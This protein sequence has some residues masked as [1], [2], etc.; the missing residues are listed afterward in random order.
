[1]CNFVKL[2]LTITQLTLEHINFLQKKQY[3]FGN[4]FYYPTYVVG[5]INGILIVDTAAASQILSD[6]AAFYQDNKFVYIANREMSHDVDLTVYKLINP[7]KM[8]GIAIVAKS[9]TAKNQI[10]QEQKRY[11]G[12]FGYFKNMHSAISWAQLLMSQSV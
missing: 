7:K 4:V 11:D 1:M 9:G 6:I 10:E 8:I 12:S 2:I 5:E 3:D